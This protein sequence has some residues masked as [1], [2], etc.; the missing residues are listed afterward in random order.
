MSTW[1]PGKIIQIKH[2]TDQLFSLIIDAQFNTFIP[3]QF[4]KIGIKINGRFIYRAYSHVNSPNHP[5]LEFY[6]TKTKSGILTTILHN[7]CVGDI[8]MISKESYGKFTLNNIPECINLWMIASGT[9]ISPYLSI[10]DSLDKRL[11]NFIRIILIHAVRYSKNLN[12]LTKIMA[13]KKKYQKRLIIQTILSQEYSSNTLHG[14]IPDLI[15]NNL[16]EKKVHLNLN[17]NSHIMLCGNPYMIVDTKKI[18]NKKY[19]MK[20][21][22]NKNIGQITQ[23]R[24]W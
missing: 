9:G 14:R 12:Y 13:F 4:S 19:G 2:W 10:L 20:I 17:Q 22:S 1:I 18:L 8:L 21:H 24:Y 7:A 15:E 16:L 23:E 3:G 6:I 11:Y 5:N